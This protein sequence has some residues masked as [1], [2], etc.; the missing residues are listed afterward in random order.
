[1]IGR[2]A[3]IGMAWLDLAKYAD[4]LGDRNQL[5]QTYIDIYAKT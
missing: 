2:G 5:P 3:G 1:V 4:W